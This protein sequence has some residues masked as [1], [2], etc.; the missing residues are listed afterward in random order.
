MKQYQGIAVSKGIGIG[1]L[2][3]YRPATANVGHLFVGKSPEE[4]LLAYEKVRSQA[5]RDLEGLQARMQEAN[6]EQSEIFAAQL[7]ILT[8]SVIEEE[9]LSQVRD[10]ALLLDESIH[11]IYTKY[12]LMMSAMEDPVFQER[13]RDIED[14]RDRL[15]RLCG[16]ECGTGLDLPYPCILAAKDLLPSDTAVLDQKNILAIVTEHGAQ[17]S[18]AAIIARGYGIP[19]IVGIGCFLDEIQEGQ[20][21]VVDACEGTLFVDM[22][23]KTR[24]DYMEKKNRFAI[25]AG[26][27]ATYLKKTAVTKDGT[28]VD[29]TLNI[30]T[31]KDEDLALAP[32]VDG[33]GLFRT[34][35]LFLGR[36]DLPGEDE[37]VAVY[38][39]ILSAFGE[40]PVILRTLDIGGDKQ[41]EC[42]ELPKE[43]NPFL[44]KRALRLCFAMP[45]V[46]RTQL[47]AALR[48]SSCGTLWLMLPMVGSMDDIY[49]AKEIL[50][51]VQAELTR[52]GIP[53]D[54]GVKLGIMVEI[55]SIALLADMAVHEVDFASIG[56][57]DL[58]QYLMAADR[59]N[60]EVAPYYQC[61]NPA[62]FR[63]IGHV[64][65]VFSSQG[66]PISLCGEL[67]GDP[68]S[69]LILVGLG[70]RKLS[71]GADAIA[72]VK[73]TLSSIRID[74]AEQ[75]A[76]LVSSMKSEREVR[77]Y[78]KDTFGSIV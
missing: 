59:L 7:D 76:R 46:F 24:D 71:M 70:I 10:A 74:E 29:I 39:R 18:H 58:C 78:M 34:E 63:L 50:S 77:Q 54:S 48:A 11:T 16:G 31:T 45:E 49:R 1:S 26:E 23:Q 51:E 20:A 64:V 66:K 52:E 33:V 65:R 41:A 27:T 53:Y 13:A 61:M 42:L 57:N 38:R 22:D 68:L 9:I 2:H 35:F 14:V 72:G 62:L 15:L 69:A 32:Y 60:P 37:Q 75:A 56:T 47:R 55:P 25:Q 12:S 44:G 30:A 43:N 8:D 36:K 19:A 67:G 3:I 40:K 28:R 5:I 6:P 21:A 73:R 4:Q 17:T